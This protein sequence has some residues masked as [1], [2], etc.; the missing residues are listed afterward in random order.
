MT[1]VFHDDASISRR[2]ALRLGGLTVAMAAVI[3]ACDN[4][5]AADQ[6]A[7]VG[8][9]PPLSALPDVSPSDVTLLRTC[10]SLQHS[11]LGV[12]TTVV[13]DPELLAPENQPLV[14]RL[15]ADAEA[16]AKVFEDL[17]VAQGGEVWACGNTKFDS[18]LIEPA[19]ARITV[20]TPATAEAQTIPASDDKR[21]DVLNLVHGMESITASTYQQYVTLLNDLALH[22]PTIVAAVRG[23]RHSALLALTI[24]PDNY[25]SSEGE[26]AAEVTPD[27]AGDTSPSTTAQ[28]IGETTTT[29]TSSTDAGAPQ[30]TEIPPVYALPWTFGS[31]ATVTVVL[32]AGDENGTRL[33]VLLET[34][35]INSMEYEYLGPCPA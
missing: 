9:A 11:L 32:G 21:R 10:S 35:A 19:M 15:I 17:T 20:G 14:R 23:A 26:S 18:A 4:T 2:G 3:A 25:V 6:P 22:Q 31:T 34:P 12:Y 30:Q 33:K 1:R 24:N 16:T 5:E 28:N 7:R 29:A 13:D 27:T 8:S